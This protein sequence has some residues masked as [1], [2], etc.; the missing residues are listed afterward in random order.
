MAGSLGVWMNGEHVGVWRTSRTGTATFKYDMNWMRSPSTRALSLSLPITAGESEHRG[1]VVDNFFENLLPDSTSIRKRISL[2]FRTKSTAAFALLTAIGRDCAGAVQ[3]LP[4]GAEPQGWNRIESEPLDEEQVERILID[5]TSDVP[6]GQRNENDD[7]RISIAG[8]QEKTALLRFGGVWRRPHAATPTTHILKLPLGM[9]GNMRADM[10]DSVENEWLCAQ[11]ARELG[12]SVAATEMAT[13]G[14]QRTLV[15]ERFDRRWQGITD[16]AQNAGGFIPADGTWIAR[17][18]QEDMCQATG[19]PPTRRYES[20]GGPSMLTCLEVLA[21]S[22]R[23]DLARTH[24]VLTQL[25]FWLLA[26]TDGHA[27]NFSIFHH[28]GG[29]FDVTPLYDVISAWPII[30]N[31]PNLLPEHDARLAMGLHS[32]NAHYKL[33]EIRVRHWMDLARNCGVPGVWDQ[34]LAMVREVDDAL[35]RVEKKLPKDYPARIWNRVN[36]GVKRYA[37][38]FLQEAD[39]AGQPD[40]TDGAANRRMLGLP[41]G[42]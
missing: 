21:S 37:M 14:R 26:A 39:S 23:A 18:P 5:A 35:G 34:M 30:G 6:L 25:V 33:R 36:A 24:F 4:E 15:V 7:F 12:L 17:L 8:A 1:D 19:T 28:R 16:N 31:G 3:L 40:P 10:T 27:K 9:V 32:R 13:F 2:R 22:E 11:I 42:D 38:Q 29:T 20:D 41:V